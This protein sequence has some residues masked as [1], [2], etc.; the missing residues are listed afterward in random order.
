MRQ[1]IEWTPEDDELLL[2]MHPTHSMREIGEAMTPPRTKNSIIS[3]ANRLGLAKPTQSSIT[4]VNKQAAKKLASPRSLKQTP[5]G[6]VVV[7]GL[8]MEK[9]NQATCKWPL[10]NNKGH[11]ERLFCGARS[12]P[13]KSYCAAHHWVAHDHKPGKKYEHRRSRL[14]GGLMT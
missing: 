12:A 3:R 5:A 2:A 6:P 13:G 8:G 9:L 1:G 4:R 11:G 10:W 7:V 14:H